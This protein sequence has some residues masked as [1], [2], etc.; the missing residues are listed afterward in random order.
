M[1]NGAILQMSYV[2]GCLSWSLSSG[3]AVSV[4]VANILITNAS[5]VPASDALFFRPAGTNLEA[6][7]MTI[8]TRRAEP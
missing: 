2:R 5:V 7:P 8:E 3:R 4:E 1:K 6:H